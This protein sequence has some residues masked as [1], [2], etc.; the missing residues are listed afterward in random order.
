MEN[1]VV[2][3]QDARKKKSK[4]WQITGTKVLSIKEL[5]HLIGLLNKYKGERDSIVLR[6]LLYT[7]ARG[8]EALQVRPK[9]LADNQVTIF[10]AK[11][12]NDRTIALPVAFFREIEE[13]SKDMDRDQPIFKIKTR[14]LRRI[15]DKWRPNPERSLHSTR[16]SFAVRLYEVCNN[17]IAV[18]AN[19][20]HRNIQNSMTYLEYVETTLNMRKH[21][22][23]MWNFKKVA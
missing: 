17:I 13:F 11:G 8:C 10:G 3:I 18:K 16:H 20:G 23:G 6:L 1:K 19:L 2:N 14:Q 21:I 5:A 7:G 22:T 4:P 9:D 15:W 12:S